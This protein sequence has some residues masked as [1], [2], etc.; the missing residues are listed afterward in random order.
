M[1][2]ESEDKKDARKLEMLK[3][4]HDIKLKENKEKNKS[5][6]SKQKLDLK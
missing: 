6:L 4:N 1:I 3:L 2:I 5:L